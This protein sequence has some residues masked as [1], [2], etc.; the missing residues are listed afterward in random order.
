M[1]KR[2]RSSG[3]D[4]CRS[5]RTSCKPSAPI[6]KPSAEGNLYNAGLHDAKGRWLVELLFE[7]QL[8]AAWA[9]RNPSKTPLITDKY[10]STG[11]PA[12]QE[13]R[14]KE[15]LPPPCHQDHTAGGSID[16]PACQPGAKIA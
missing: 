1:D 3:E 15:T 7:H 9:Q 14:I 12:E 8:G 16:P 5:H 2:Q 11:Q 13:Y 6:H 4:K 10:I